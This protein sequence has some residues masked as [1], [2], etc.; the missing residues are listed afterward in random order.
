M[1]QVRIYIERS[2]FNTDKLLT[3]PDAPLIGDIIQ[4]SSELFIENEDDH[5]AYVNYLK[6]N[7]LFRNEAIVTERKW[8]LSGSKATEL[9]LVLK[10][11]S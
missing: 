4:L 3:F 10:L 9:I 6:N 8:H 1:T 2:D 5:N 7:H 11:V